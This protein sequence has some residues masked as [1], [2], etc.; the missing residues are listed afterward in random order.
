MDLT[1]KTHFK[2]HIPKPE[3]L[4]DKECFLNWAFG[5]FLKELDTNFAPQ[6]EGAKESLQNLICQTFE[7]C[8]QKIRLANELLLIEQDLW[9]EPP[10]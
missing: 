6:I 10:D 7:F 3:F 4:D 8:Y 1:P 5:N 9:V 2:G